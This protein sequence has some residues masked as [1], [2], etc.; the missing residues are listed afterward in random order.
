LDEEAFHYRYLVD[1]Q[2]A[3]ANPVAFY[4]PANIFAAGHF[5]D[6]LDVMNTLE[7]ATV[8]MHL[9]AMRQL[10]EQNEPL[11]AEILGQI[12]A[13]EA[14]HRVMGREMAQNSP[15]APN[16]LC[17]E[18][19]DFTCASEILSALGRYFNGGV[20][21]I[22]PVAL[23]DQ[24]AVA[25]A[26]GAAT[27][28]VVDAATAS[29]C[30]DT[31]ADILHTAAQAEA[32]GIA[33]Y[34]HGITG[35][36]FDQLHQP[37]QWYLQAALDEENHHL[38]FLLEN[39]A[40]P[41]ASQFFFPQGVFDDLA[42][43]LSILDMLENIFIGA[44]LAAIQRLNQ[45]GEPLLAEIA[46]QILGVESEHRVLGRVLAAHLL[47]HNRCLAQVHYTCIAQAAADLEPFLTGSEGFTAQAPLPTE[48]EIAL[49]VD[50][51]G[52]IPTPP[53]S[54]PAPVYLPWVAR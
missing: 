32:T 10:G 20:G 50:A 29:T 42:Q 36:F 2:G 41:P 47:P 40:A 48:P 46:A 53:A 3:S 17:Y 25:T 35:G 5:A 21:F 30:D 6:F 16:N 43:F 9:A 33:L 23:P 34:Y 1:Q 45:L 14:E 28:D 15:P 4:F 8:A 24:N 13:I 39:G 26:V 22:G 19:A 7:T 51:F 52:C 11:R 44:Y 54:L 18:R 27:C 38:H 12:A 49:A 31:L 37:Q